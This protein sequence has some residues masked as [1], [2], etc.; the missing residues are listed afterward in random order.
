MKFRIDFNRRFPNANEHLKKISDEEHYDDYGCKYYEIDV[1]IEDLEPLWA[2]VKKVTA[3]EYLFII[4][5]DPPYIY[6]DDDV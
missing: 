1:S 5:F 4:T 6:L 2:K 3:I